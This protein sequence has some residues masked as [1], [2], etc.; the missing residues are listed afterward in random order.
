MEVLSR[1]GQ[2]RA[3]EEGRTHLGRGRPARVS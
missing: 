2:R 3:E 1:G